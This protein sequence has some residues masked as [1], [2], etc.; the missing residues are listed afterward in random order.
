VKPLYTWTA[1]AVVV[2]ASTTGDVLVSRAMKQ[3]GDLGVLWREAGFFAIVSRILRN[4]KF[5]LGLLAMAIAFYALLFV[6]SWTDVSLVA[7]AS[8]SLTFIANAIAA[9][10]F[11][12]ERVDHMR[13]ASALLVAGGVVLLAF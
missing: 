7:P 13:W 3:V 10:I 6:L 8:A 1:I 12:K 2:L 4:P 5:L 9:R 11:L